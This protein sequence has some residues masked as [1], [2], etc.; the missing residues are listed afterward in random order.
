MIYVTI[1]NQEACLCPTLVAEKIYTKP[2]KMI[3]KQIVWKIC[4]TF[5]QQANAIGQ[6]MRT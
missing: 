5:S 6:W 1:A 3:E 2:D 4:L